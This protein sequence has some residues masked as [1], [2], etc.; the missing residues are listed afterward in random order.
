MHWRRRFI[1]VTVVVVLI[2]AGLGADFWFAF[3]Q[4][5]R[6]PLTGAES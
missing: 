5:W 4:N 3:V 6:P 1:V 2:L